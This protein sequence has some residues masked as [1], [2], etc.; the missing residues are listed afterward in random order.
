MVPLS[1]TRSSAE[2]ECALPLADPQATTSR[3]QLECNH[4]LIIA[5]ILTNNGHT[6]QYQSIRLIGIVLTTISTLDPVGNSLCN[7]QSFQFAK[8]SSSGCVPYATRSPSL[9]LI[10]A[11]HHEPRIH[12]TESPPRG[13]GTTTRAH[14]RRVGDLPSNVQIQREHTVHF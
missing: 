12:G 7:L 11:D 9:V 5:P 8:R 14:N 3:Q 6:V 10:A 1:H 2:P 13:A 4:S